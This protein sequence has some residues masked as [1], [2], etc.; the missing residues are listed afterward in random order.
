[1]FG[2]NR[3]KR[4]S[5]NPELEARLRTLDDRGYSVIPPG[6]LRGLVRELPHIVDTLGCRILHLLPI[7]PVPTTLAR[8]GRFGS[9]YALQHLTAVDPALVEFDRRSTGLEQ[10]GELAYAVHSRGHV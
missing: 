9:P 10:F 4:T 7:N 5:E 3:T 8:F 6:T 1:M 2:P